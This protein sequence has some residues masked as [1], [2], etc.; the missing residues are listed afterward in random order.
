MFTN[1]VYLK[2][3][4]LQPFIN[5]Y[6]HKKPREIYF[7]LPFGLYWFLEPLCGADGE[8]RNSHGR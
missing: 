5:I 6:Y 2:S 8:T 7:F 1:D 4:I 3:W